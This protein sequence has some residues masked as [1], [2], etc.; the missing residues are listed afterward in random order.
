MTRLGPYEVVGE[1]GRGASGLV[2]RGRDPS[3]R[4]VALKLLTSPSDPR[5]V[6]RLRREGLLA[7][8]LSHPGI[9]AVHDLVTLQDGRLLLVSELVEGRTLEEAG[10]TLDRSGRV[11]LVRQTAAAMAHAHRSGV[12]H[13]D[14]K[15][16]N[17]LVEAATGAVKVIDFGLATAQDL[18]RLT[19][20]G[21]IVGTPSHMSPEQLLGEPAGAPADVWVLG[22]LLHEALVG[23]PPFPATAFLELLAQVTGDPVAPLRGHDPSVP[24][25]LEAVTLRALARAPADRFAD[26]GEL[27]AALDDRSEERRVG[28]ECRSR[29]SPYH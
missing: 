5:R 14:L 15:P 7:G 12:V 6:E 29:W 24:P 26:A 22:V 3:G 8:R 23:Q 13:R 9:A 27:L 20:T 21:A 1:L 25:A 19:R 10:R 18:E 28:K 11:E 4:P 16:A 2:L 17:V